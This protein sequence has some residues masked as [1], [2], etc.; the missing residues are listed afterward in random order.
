MDN[1][2]NIVKN[3][4]IILIPTD[5]VYGIATLDTPIYMKKIYDIKKREEDKKIIALI[6][7]IDKVFEILE[8]SKLVEFL[9]NSFF[10]GKLSIIAKSNK[11]YYEK[12]DYEYIG[13]RMPNNEKALKIIDKSGGILMTSSANI[14]GEDTPDKFSNISKE[15]LNNVDG[16]IID[17]KNVGKVSSTI[18]KIENDKIY[19]LREGEIKFKDILKY[20]E[21]K[22][23]K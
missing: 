4:G 12:L 17:D 6:S 15:I 8:Y 11:K 3:G 1:L 21:E 13:V 22:F 23:E 18:I 2:V 9:V 16:Y 10:P 7:S 20:K 19:L 5:T 14:S